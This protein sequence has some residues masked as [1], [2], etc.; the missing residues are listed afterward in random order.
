MIHITRHAAERYCQRIDPSLSTE[1]AFAELRSHE[2]AFRAAVDFGCTTVR[3]GKKARAVLSCEG[4]VV[5]VIS[6]WM[7]RPHD[8]ARRGAF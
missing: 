6:G 7:S 3:F 2:K 4:N 1:E 8:L 5:T